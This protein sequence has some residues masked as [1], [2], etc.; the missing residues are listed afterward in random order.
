MPNNNNTLTI[1]DKVLWI[2][3]QVILISNICKVTAAVPKP[4]FPANVVY[5]LIAGIACFA[6]TELNSLFALVGIALVIIAAVGGY[7]WYMASSFPPK[8]L[9]ISLNSGEVIRLI[10]ED[11][12]LIDSVVRELAAAM[13]GIFR[14]FSIDLSNAQISNSQVGTIGSFLSNGGVSKNGK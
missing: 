5:S 11:H 9:S 14:S 4:S 2:G 7:R 13:K 6:L 10:S 8:G 12:H 3:D 1:D